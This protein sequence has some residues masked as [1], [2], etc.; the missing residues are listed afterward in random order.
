MI[1]KSEA[2]SSGESPRVAR[3][4][5]KVTVGRAQVGRNIYAKDSES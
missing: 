4:G 3:A 2:A 1:L 5:K